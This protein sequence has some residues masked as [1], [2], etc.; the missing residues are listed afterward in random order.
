[1]PE[2]YEPFLRQLRRDLGA[3]LP[4]RNAQYQ[5][6]PRPR[7]GGEFDDAPRAD[8]RRGG[9]LALL[10]PHAGQVYLPLILRP[11][12]P[13]VHSG[14][15]GFPG[16]GY[17]AT[18]GDLTATALRETYEE[19]GVHASQYTVL[20]Q[21]TSLYVSASNYL[22]QP[23]VGWIDY[24]PT[25]N[26]DPYEVAALI[27]APLTTLLDPATRRVEPWTLRGREIVVPFFALGDFGEY[28]VWGA[29]AMMLGELL[30]LPAMQVAPGAQNNTSHAPG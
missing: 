16:G 9:V 7:P 11:T 3:P 1:M 5:M 8:A 13:G 24:R 15:I 19:I 28:T 29:T 18:D 10:Y 12:Y 22:V 30:A 2:I 20:G 21:L 23:I 4:G 27:E 6:A 14:Q 17:E 25:F 26:P